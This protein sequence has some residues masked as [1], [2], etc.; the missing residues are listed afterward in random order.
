MSVFEASN[1]AV[2]LLVFPLISRGFVGVWEYNTGTALT[3]LILNKQIQVQSHDCPEFCQLL[4]K[5][6]GKVS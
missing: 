3:K 6:R 4:F 5:S 2:E 1:V